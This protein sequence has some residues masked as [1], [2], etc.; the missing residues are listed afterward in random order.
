M[1]FFEIEF[2]KSK[3]LV[4]FKYENDTN[5]NHEYINFLHHVWIL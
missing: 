5:S 1:I 3:V 2:Q 4:D